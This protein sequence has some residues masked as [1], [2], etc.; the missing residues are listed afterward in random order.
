MKVEL[1][2][3]DCLIWSTPDDPKYYSESMKKDNHIM[4][5]RNKFYL[6][7]L[8]DAVSNYRLARS[9]TPLDRPSMYLDKIRTALIGL[10]IR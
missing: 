4:T 7:D 5:P 9:S 1:H 8:W 3:N 10:D 2:D 6:Y